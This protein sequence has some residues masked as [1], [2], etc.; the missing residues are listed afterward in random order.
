MLKISP[1]L[2]QRASLSIALAMTLGMTMA[3]AQTSGGTSEPPMVNPTGTETDSMDHYLNNH[4]GVANEL[5]NNPSLINDPQWLA[6]HPKVQNYMNDHPAMKTDAANNPAGF[7]HQTEHH[8]LVSDHRALNSTDS[9]MKNH[10]QVAQELKNN[11]KLVDD[12]K[13]LA[14]HPELDNYLA[15]H[16]EIRK[17]AQAHPDSFAKATE[18]N[19]KYNNTHK[20]PPPPRK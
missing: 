10:P 8:D 14:Q 20:I 4:P 12:P 15:K 11:P 17:E 9:F 2:F 7:V 18:A 5:H 19:N 6:S 3:V 1:R 16:P 13:Y